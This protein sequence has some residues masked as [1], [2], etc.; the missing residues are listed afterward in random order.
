MKG[1]TATHGVRAC[2]SELARDG[3]TAGGAQVLGL[4][5]VGTLQVGDRLVVDDGVIPDLDLEQLRAEARARVQQLLQEVI[6][7]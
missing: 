3:G 7:G 4:G 5:A 1:T 2:R 6:E